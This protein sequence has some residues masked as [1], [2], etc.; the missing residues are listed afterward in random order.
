MSSII[1]N[2]KSHEAIQGSC[3]TFC[4]EAYVGVVDTSCVGAGVRDEAGAEIGDG[5]A[6]GAGA[7]YGSKPGA[8]EQPLEDSTITFDSLAVVG[9]RNGIG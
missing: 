5:A 1:S 8:E 4:L 9:A 6:A 2:S 7:R 3:D